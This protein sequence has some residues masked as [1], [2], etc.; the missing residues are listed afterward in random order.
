[1]YSAG[2]LP[3]ERHTSVTASPGGNGK[4]LSIA[5]TPPCSGVSKSPSTTGPAPLSM[6]TS[7]T[8]AAPYP[9]EL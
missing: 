2:G 3:V 5:F 6:V 9:N 7:S 4:R 1:M 8:C